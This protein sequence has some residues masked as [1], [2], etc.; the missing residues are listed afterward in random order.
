ME[1]I[2]DLTNANAAS[3]L[4]GSKGVL[5]EFY[6]P[7]CGHCKNLAP[8]MVKLGQALIKAK[9]TIV[10]VAKINC[11][12]ERDVCSKYGVQGYPTLK[13]FP[14]GSSEPIEYNSGRT[15]EAMVDFINQK[16]PSSRLRI[17]KEPT[18]VEDL[19]P[20]TFDKIVLDSEK[21]VLVKF[22]APWCGHCK[23]MAPD[24]EKVAKA[25]LN[26][27]SV[28]VAHVDC[29][30]Y[31]DLCSKYGVQGYP[32]LKFFPAKENK[33]AEEYNSGR[34]APAFLEFL[35][36]KAGTSRN[37][38]GALSE[39][40]GVLASMVGPVKKFL[41][42]STV[43]DKKKVIAEVEATVSSLVGAAKANAD[44]YAKAMARIVEKGAEYVATEVARLE[45]ILAGG[46]VSGDR[47]DAMKIRMN[48]LKTFN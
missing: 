38:E 2:I 42:A 31:R 47:A 34:E 16:E 10:A 39:K 4:D 46:S 7:W 43:E 37:I 33:E 24:Y 1:G 19:S 5:V 27:K 23:K 14:R 11:D 3:V 48:V 45:K 36:N 29:D 28:V 26:E 22:Y 41:A 32:T 12:N 13:Y 35:N 18:F 30:K 25:F 6:A 15:V 20:Q 8:E 17:A 9:P 40:A 21:N 44:V